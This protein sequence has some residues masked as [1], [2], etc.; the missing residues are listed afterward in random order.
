MTCNHC[1][2]TVSEAINLCDGIK[3]SKINLE[4]GEVLIFGDNL[5]EDEIISSIN[6]VG[7]SV[8]KIN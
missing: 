2:E 5:K 7:F 3:D 1:K 4:S 8:G 6:N